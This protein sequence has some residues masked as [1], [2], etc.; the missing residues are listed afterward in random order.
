MKGAILGLSCLLLACSRPQVIYQPQQVKVP[1]I[2]KQ[3]APKIPAKPKLPQF[4]PDDPPD[5]RAKKLIEAIGI[6]MADDEQ[7][8]ELLRAYE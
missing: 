3:P 6:L 7:L 5:V 8:R 1:V 2:V 4:L